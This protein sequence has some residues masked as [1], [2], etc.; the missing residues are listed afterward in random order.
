MKK[1]IITLFTLALIGF[2]S[3]M[4]AEPHYGSNPCNPNPCE[5]N[6]CLNAC[7]ENPCE[8]MYP[9]PCE[10]ACDKKDMMKKNACQPCNKDMKKKNSCNPCMKNNKTKKG[11]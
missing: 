5:M 2:G 4:S 11:N 6:P 7:M 9:N 1:K 8:Y 3:W 10:N